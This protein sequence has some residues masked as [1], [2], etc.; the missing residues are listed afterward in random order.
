MLDAVALER[1]GVRTVT[2]V[3]DTFARAAAATARM[4][5]SPDMRFVVTPSRKAAE[6]EEDQRAK[7]RGAVNEVVGQLAA[8][9]GDRD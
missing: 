2:I 7:A 5:G 3:W 6:S 8:S 4:K 1:M 9:G